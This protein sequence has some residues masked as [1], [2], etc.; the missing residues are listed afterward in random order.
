MLLLYRNTLKCNVWLI[1]KLPETNNTFKV[2][3]ILNES[4]LMIL[5]GRYLEFPSVLKTCSFELLQW[6]QIWVEFGFY[7]F[8]KCYLKWIPVNREVTKFGQIPILGCKWVKT[9]RKIFLGWFTYLTFKH[10]QKHPEQWWHHQNKNVT[11]KGNCFE[12]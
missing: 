9:N 10:F 1:K 8:A 4:S 2:D 7:H 3:V 5:I 6:W 11:F 12:R